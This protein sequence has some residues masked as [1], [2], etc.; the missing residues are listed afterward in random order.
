MP[1]RLDVKNLQLCLGAYI[2]THILIRLVGSAGGTVKVDQD[3]RGKTL[4]FRKDKTG[5]YLFID[6]QEVFHFPLKDYQKGFSLGY[7]RI[8]PTEDGVGRMIVLSREVDPYAP[9]LPEPR[10]SFLRI[11]LDNHLMEIFFEGRVNLKFHSWWVKPRWKY[12]VID[13]PDRKS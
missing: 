1:K 5:L 11:V 9:N 6:A 8:E 12:W 10:W 4:R 7:E 2:P 3:L 13:G